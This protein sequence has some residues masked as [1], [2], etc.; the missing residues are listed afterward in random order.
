LLLGLSC[1][2]QPQGPAYVA[3]TETFVF[4]FDEKGK[5]LWKTPMPG[6]RTWAF[7]DSIWLACSLVPAVLVAI[8]PTTGKELWR[9]SGEGL[10]VGAALDSIPPDCTLVACTVETATAMVHM[11]L[12]PRTGHLLA[13]WTRPN[14]LPWPQPRQG[15]ACPV[16]ALEE[17]IE[18]AF[19]SATAFGFDQNAKLVWRL[20]LRPEERPR[21]FSMRYVV[22]GTECGLRVLD[23]RTGNIL[24]ERHYPSAV[25]SL[26]GD[27]DYVQ[28]GLADG[29]YW[30]H[31]AATGKPFRPSQAALPQQR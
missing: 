7:S 23:R 2:R 13:R 9:W 20:P 14:E 3:S 16:Q 26:S 8:E 15:A 18:V 29:T 11:R 28:V 27:E 30:L 17:L 25:Q 4:G 21:H 31:E 19:S 6:F 1:A 22:L 12:H 5:V 24:W 10:L